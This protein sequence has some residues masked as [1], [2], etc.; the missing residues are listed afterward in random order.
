MSDKTGV[1]YLVGTPIGNLSDLSERGRET[2]E[3][4]DFI[5][6]EDTRV[7]SKLLS[8]FQIK[9]PL[10]S[11]HQHN[12]KQSGDT[13][14]TRLLKGE[15]GALVTDAGMPCISDPGELLVKECV[16]LGIDLVVVP[17]PS[18]LIAALAV[19]GLDTSRFS[20]EGFLSVTKKQRNKHL[21]D[22]KSSSNTLIFYEA[23]HKL[24]ATLEDMLAVLGDRKAALCR[25]MTKIHEQ[26]LRGTLSELLQ[27]H[28]STPPRGEYV[29][30][31]EGAKE[32]DQ[33][34]GG[35]TLEDALKRVQEYRNQ[36]LSPTQACKKAAAE[37]GF[38]KSELYRYTVGN[39]ESI[40]AE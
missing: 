17:G 30:V 11:Y 2:L 3:S 9:K 1:L 34:A 40:S 12:A 8:R 37:S 23:P 38:S 26:V 5:A 13:I 14:I 6:A 28:V 35:L 25:E 24:I 33:N 32:Q 36:G 16:K 27:Y 31:I 20:F 21:Q 7:T 19:S 15:N 29:L 4:V 10:V 22:I 18:A 39:T